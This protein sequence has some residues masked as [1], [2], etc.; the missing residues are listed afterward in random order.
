MG[1]KPRFRPITNAKFDIKE[2]LFCYDD[3][4]FLNLNCTYPLD[5]FVEAFAFLL[6]KEN[7]HQEACKRLG[8]NE[9]V[10]KWSGYTLEEWETDFKAKIDLIKYNEKEKELKALEKK[11]A[12][13]LSEEGKTSKMLEDIENLLND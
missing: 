12:E 11:L 1:E 6:E 5:V 9:K 7:R 4:G 2:N 8:V 3:I 10:F 13:L